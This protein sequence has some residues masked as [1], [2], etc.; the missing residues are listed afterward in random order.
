M[1]RVRPSQTVI[2]QHTSIK[3]ADA[4]STD[5]LGLSFYAEAPAAEVSIREFEELA[6]DRLKLLHAFDRLCGYDMK[7]DQLVEVKQKL[8]KELATSRLMLTYP[9][10]DRAAS[11]PAERMEFVRRDAISHFALRLA[12]CKTR[13]TRDWFLRQE[14]RLFALR[15]EELKTDAKDIF[16]ASSGLRCKKFEHSPADTGADPM[17]SLHSL[18]RTTPGA[19]IWKGNGSMPDFD[20]HF[21]SMPFFEVHPSL[22]AHRRVVVHQGNAYVPSSALKLILSGRFKERLIAGI[23]VAFQGLP[24]ALSNPQVGGFLRFIQDNGMQLLVAPKSDKEEPGEQLTLQNFEDLMVRSFPPCMRRMVERQRETKKHLKHLGRLQLRPFLK[25]CGF[26]IDD[27][28]KW[29]QHELCKDPSIDI[30][31]YEKNSHTMWNTHM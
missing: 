14:E 23:E 18:Q 19:K 15:F 28:F 9:L 6:L 24:A 3:P 1:Q 17:P 21:Y 12:F 2:D 13:E 8:S 7:L 25:E 16:M 5:T 10:A 20:A 30:T 29:W 11:F 31:S 26:T 22:I 27:S 4:F